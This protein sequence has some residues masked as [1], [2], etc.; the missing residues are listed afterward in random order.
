MLL[1]LFKTD[2]SFSSV[3]M[4]VGHQLTFMIFPCPRALSTC[5]CVCVC[6]CLQEKSLKCDYGLAMAACYCIVPLLTSSPWAS[7]FSPMVDNV[8]QTLLF[9]VITLL[10]PGC[11][12]L[13]QSGTHTGDYFICGAVLLKPLDSFFF[14]PHRANFVINISGN[15]RW[16]FKWNTN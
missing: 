5:T 1:I 7:P 8:S 13:L 16:H 6:V 2:I 11:V 3:L 9:A 10:L 4:M 14:T 15:I 12:S